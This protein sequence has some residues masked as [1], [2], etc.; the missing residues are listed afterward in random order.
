MSAG[1]KNRRAWSIARWA[2]ILVAVTGLGADGKRSITETDLFAFQ[3]IGSPQIA[4]D[5]SKVV[6]ALVKVTSKHDDYETALWIV[7]ANGGF[8]RG[9]AP[10]PHQSRRARAPRRQLAAFL[11]APGKDGKADAPPTY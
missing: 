11:P 8:P 4:P 6:Y 3:W 9:F 7:P 10:R 5:G 1:R 2:A